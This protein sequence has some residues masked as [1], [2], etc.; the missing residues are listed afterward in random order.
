MVSMSQIL[1]GYIVRAFGIKG[2]VVIKL[3]NED[4]LTLSEGLEVTVSQKKSPNK[5]LTIES[6][7]DRGR[8]FFKEIT[9]REVAESLRGAELLVDRDTLPA[10]EDDEYYFSDMIGASIIDQNGAVIGR[11]VDFSSNNAQ[12]L[13]EIE[14]ASGK[15][16][17]IPAV[18]PIVL[19]I[20]EKNQQITV[21]LPQGLLDL[22]A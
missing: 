12:T 14:T 8:V 3:L 9:D 15:R 6:V 21:D 10:L 11:L 5:T 18:K 7:M 17:S 13:F 4:S 1:L 16:A 2:G 19:K 20:D 22:E